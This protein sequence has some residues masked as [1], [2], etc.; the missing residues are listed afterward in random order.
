[1]LMSPG[2]IM[3]GQAYTNQTNRQIEHIKFI[4]LNEQIQY[5]LQRAD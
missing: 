4:K 2:A 1:M 5:G 3:T